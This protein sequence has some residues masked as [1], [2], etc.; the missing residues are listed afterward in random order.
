MIYNVLEYLENSASLYPDKKAVA[1]NKS[2]YTYTELMEKAK[3]AGSF[4]STITETKKPVCVYMD[5]SCETLA[6]FLGIV[7]AGCFYVNIEP[8]HPAERINSIIGTLEAKILIVDDKS[9]KKAEKLG[10]EGT[11]LNINEL[12]NAKA[13]DEA[14]Y[15]LEYIRDNAIDIDPLYSI[16]TS[17]STGV[18][19]GV[20]VN[21]RSVI[22]FIETFTDK[23]GIGSDDIIGNQAPFDFD[24][25]VK[26][27]YSCV[28]T[29]A[30]L[31]IIPTKLF[32]VPPKLLDYICEKHINS[33]VWAVSALTLVSCLKGLNYRVPVEVKRVMFS[34]EVMPIKQL[35]L[36]QQAL[37]DAEFVNLYGPSEITCNCMYYRVDRTFEDNELLPL[38][39]AFEGRKI[40]LM[41]ENGHEI[42]NPGVT[43]EICVVGES[44]ARGYYNNK[45]ET[46]RKFRQIDINGETKRCYFTGDM[47]RYD[48]AGNLFFAG[49]KDFQI[50][51]MG[52][53]IELEE[54]E[55]ALNQLPGVEKSCCFMNKKR[56]RLVG[57]Y[58]GNAKENEIKSSLKR[59]LPA[60]MIPHTIVKV[61]DMPL[62]KN[63]KTDRKYFM[64][65]QEVLM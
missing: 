38:G 35:K 41:D 18:P 54:I 58:L 62:N 34:G 21:H 15:R 7:Y 60:Y 25:S 64:S 53:R 40:L 3:N 42:N 23:M 36:W 10:F 28:M 24:V 19:K 26:D 12:L 59:K 33:L 46:D 50:K 16:F 1:D 48:E 5:K 4:L 32:S 57:F 52:H 47:A 27:I 14:A 20:I 55:H 43:G 63:G 37:P 8:S 45:T 29:G 13:D 31:V 49:R 61:E 56:N 39:K 65:R 9:A 11:I 30:E 2:S 22:D 6:L 17:G 51:H 44:L